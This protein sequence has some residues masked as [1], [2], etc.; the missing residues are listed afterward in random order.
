[1]IKVPNIGAP[2]LSPAV[3]AG[4]QKFGKLMEGAGKGGP[5]LAPKGAETAL[6]SPQ[7]AGPAAADPARAQGVGRAAPGKAEVRPGCKVDSVQQA[8][9]QQAV[10][11][12]DQ[13]TAAQQRLDKV[14]EL[15]QS[16]KTFTPA[17]LIALQANVYRA[18]QE[19]DLAGKVVEKV[20]SGV[21]QILQ[22]QV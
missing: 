12:L 19:L 9:A 7:P 1:M 18:S 11:V 14:L 5:G 22:T 21:K 16:G 8:R 15:A 2:G 13:V 10:K 17:E 6:H 4:K 20:T 3:E